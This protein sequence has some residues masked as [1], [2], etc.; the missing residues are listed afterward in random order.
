MKV[1][2]VSNPFKGSL[3]SSMVG[4]IVSSELFDMGIDASYIPST[5]GGDGLIDAVRYFVKSSIIK[6]AEV[7]NPVGD[8]LST[9]RYLYDY[10]NQISYLELSE[11]SGLKKTDVLDV[12]KAST[13]GLGELIKHTIEEDHP[14]KIIIGCGGSA[15]TD[16][17]FGTL[18]ALGMKFYDENHQLVSHMNNEKMGIIKYIDDEKMRLNISGIEF[19]LWVDVGSSIDEAC[20]YFSRQK[21]AKDSDIPLII[22]NVH[23]MMEICTNQNGFDMMDG[24]GLGAAGGFPYYFYYCLDAKIQ[25]GANEFLKLS[26]FKNLIQ[27]YDVIV[28]GEGC[29][30]ESSLKGKLILGIYNMKPKHLVILSALNL[31]NIHTDI[32]SIVPSIS[33]KEES[34]KHPEES[35][36]SLVRSIDWSKYE[37]EGNVKL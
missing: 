28:S 11:A 30:D 6:D 33:S 15:S 8:S 34:M 31:S 20:T 36:R 35:L 17:G 32:Y 23:H 29:F 13:F 9:A 5:D 22:S 37:D 24:E 3:T 18:E 4:D 16:L 19:D 2:I 7:S 10:L 14:K 1:L 12:F 26:D 21:G 27:K 25:S